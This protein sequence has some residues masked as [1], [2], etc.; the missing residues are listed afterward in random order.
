MHIWECHHHTIQHY[1]KCHRCH[2]TKTFQGSHNFWWH[3]IGGNE[4]TMNIIV[5]WSGGAQRFLLNRLKFFPEWP[6]LK[7][8]ESEICELMWKYGQP[9]VF[10]KLY[11]LLFNT[12]HICIETLVLKLFAQ[13]NMPYHL[14]KDQVGL[15]WGPKDFSWFFPEWPTF[16]AS[17]F[18]EII[19]KL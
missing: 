14:F 8:S 2:K 17:E 7:A 1:Q 4:P 9:F 13:Q 11:S 5:D 18:C 3:S 15:K 19:W 16:K 6:A 10:S 12:S